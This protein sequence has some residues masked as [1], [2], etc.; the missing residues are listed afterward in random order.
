MI[1]L[2]PRSVP[3]RDAKYMSLALMVAGFSKDPHTQMGAVIVSDDNIGLGYGYN[4]PPACVDDNAVNWDRPYKYDIMLHAEDNAIDHSPPSLDNA[5]LYVTGLPCKRCMLRILSKRIP[6]VV[7][8][9]RTYDKG[10]MQ[11]VTDDIRAVH[12]LAKIGKV[13]LEKFGGDLRWLEEWV[14]QLKQMGLL[15]I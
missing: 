11:A 8:L 14:E 3:S 13:S 9:D 1:K 7:Y 2:P 5:T 6:R 4:G 10:S 12:E 15:P